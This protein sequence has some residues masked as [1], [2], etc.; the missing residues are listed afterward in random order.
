M[1]LSCNRITHKHCKYEIEVRS[2][3]NATR[4]MLNHINNVHDPSFVPR[5][6]DD[7]LIEYHHYVRQIERY[8]RNNN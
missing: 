3:S 6:Y 1:E 4:E 2:I 5:C 7:L 8:I